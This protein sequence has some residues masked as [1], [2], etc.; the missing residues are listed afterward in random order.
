MS[1]GSIIIAAVALLLLGTILP[2]P[3]PDPM[4]VCLG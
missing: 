4:T 3:E 2:S 1:I